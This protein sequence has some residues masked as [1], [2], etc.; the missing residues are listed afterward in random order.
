MQAK[1]LLLL[2]GAALSLGAVNAA[3]AG[4]TNDDIRAIVAEMMADAE[5]R[6]SLLAGGDAGHDG[7]FFIAGDGFRLNVGGQIQFRYI[8]DFRDDDVV[9]ETP[10]GDDFSNGFEIQRAKLDFAGTINRDWDFR[11][12]GAAKTN[13]EGADSNFQLEEAWGRYNFSNGMKFRF[14]QFKLPLLREELVSSKYQLAVE[15]SLVNEAFTQDRS[16]GIELSADYETWRWAVAFSDGL[17]SENTNYNAGGPNIVNNA[18]ISGEA[19]YAFT[20]RVEFLFSGNWKMFEDF[21]SAKGQDFGFLLGGAAHW[22]QS[23][24]TGDPAD[25]DQDVFQATIDASFEGDS[26]NAFLA[27]IYRWVSIEDSPSGDD[28]VNDFGFVAQAG[29]RFAENT[30]VFA[31]YELF[32][33]DEDRFETFADDDNDFHFITF[34][35]NQYLAGHAA[36][37]TLDAVYTVTETDNLTSG[38]GFA[39][40]LPDG[41][42]EL[43]GNTEEGE[44]T[45]RL[46]MQLLF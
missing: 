6:S 36:K 23:T 30:E 45:V 18:S 33:L 7:R 10:P 34:G 5:T 1:S 15:R 35:F 27:G 4:Q 44:I 24:Q 3:Q 42:T 39:G 37:A 32:W 26:W 11:I 38:A 14:G 43:L 29:W 28:D 13:D 21:T 20:G 2:T 22:Q 46:Q 40:F 16:Q 12:L 31:R 25:I 41:N 17:D 8:M 9:D 19:E